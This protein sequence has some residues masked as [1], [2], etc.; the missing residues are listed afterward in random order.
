MKREEKNQKMRRKI[1]DSA[2]TEFSNQGY[3]SVLS[4]QSVQLKIFQKGS[5]I[6]ILKQ[7]TIYI[8]HV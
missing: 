2:L 4:I 1:I 5:C 3:V 7:K 6:T 8:W